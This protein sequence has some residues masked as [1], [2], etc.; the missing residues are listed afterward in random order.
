MVLASLMKPSKRC[1]VYASS[2]RISK[3]CRATGIHSR[4]LTSLRHSFLSRSVA[5]DLADELSCSV[6]AGG[7]DGNRHWSTLS[8]MRASERQARMP[9]TACVAGERHERPCH[10]VGWARRR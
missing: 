8:T 2:A 9:T 5:G 1:S 6:D 4:T 3:H 7:L 10:V